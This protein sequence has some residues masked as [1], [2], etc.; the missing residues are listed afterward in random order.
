MQRTKL[1]SLIEEQ[2]CS[3][4][5]CVSTFIYPL[6]VAWESS[7]ECETRLH[8]LVEFADKMV[9]Q[10]RNVFNSLTEGRDFDRK[11]IQAIVQVFPERALPHHLLDLVLREARGGGDGDGLGLARGAVLGRHVEDPVGVDVEG[12]LDLRDAARGGGNAH[13]VELAESPAVPGELALSL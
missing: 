2:F 8:F 13:Q 5:T 1:R 7:Q 9:D 6:H 10:Q 4:F 12:H 3:I 11:D